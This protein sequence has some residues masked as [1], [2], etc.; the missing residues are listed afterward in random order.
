MFCLCGRESKHGMQVVTESVQQDNLNDRPPK[1]K[2]I[3]KPRIKV[4]KDDCG[5]L[6]V[7]LATFYNEDSNASIVSETSSISV[8]KSPDTEWE[9]TESEELEQEDN[10]V[11]SDVS[12]SDISLSFEQSEEFN[13]EIDLFR[14]YSLI[15]EGAESGTQ[16]ADEENQLFEITG[17]SATNLAASLLAIVSLHNGSDALLS[18]LLK[19]DQLLF[20]GQTISPWAFRKQFENFCAKYQSSKQ[21]FHN[22]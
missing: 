21:S 4:M 1:R 3:A 17:A 19:R 22:G 18:D 7:D 20:A 13:H 9:L 5:S 10:E 8:V 11:V 12:C 2:W 14:D 15:E 6:L 16:E